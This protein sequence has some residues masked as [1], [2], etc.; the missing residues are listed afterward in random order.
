MIVSRAAVLSGL[1]LSALTG[2]CTSE[3]VTTA[4]KPVRSAV[5]GGTGSFALVPDGK[6]VK[7]YLPGYAASTNTPSLAVVDVSAPGDGVKGAPALLRQI[8]LG[9]GDGGAVEYATT[10]AG[11]STMIVAASTEASLV[12]FV[13]PASDTVIGTLRLD[14]SYGQSTFGGNGGYVTFVAM[15][16]ARN[17]AI[18]G[19]WNGLALVDLT[20]L[21][22]TKT[23]DAP[24][25]ENFAFDP[26]RQLVFAPF[27]DCAS[28]L[29]SRGNTPRACDGLTAPDGT[30]M[31]DGLSVVDLADDTVYT[32]QNPAADDPAAPVGTSPG[33]AAVDPGSGLV[34]VPSKIHQY[35][36]TIDFSRAVFDR[37][38]HVVTA[39]ATVLRGNGLTDVAIAPPDHLAFWEGENAAD[40]AA[41]RVLTL[42]PAA[43]FD[44]GVPIADAGAPMAD[45]GVPAGPDYVFS[46]MPAL[47]DGTPFTNLV[48]SHG[49]AVWPGAN[50]SAPFGIT[51]SRDG[52]WVA[53][54][55]LRTVLALPA[56]YHE[57]SDVTA[58]VT[59]LDSQ[60]PSP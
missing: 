23:I 13:D 21:A 14:A 15:D 52:R 33:S 47:P 60:T 24:P 22:I 6:S 54:V 2:A 45:A 38:T 4:A 40:I 29:D 3:N 9:D 5:A 20:T 25:S 11:D 59:F 18:L 57:L 36:T 28:S 7:L 35:Q 43:P 58:A 42:A 44:G 50:D 49:V 55:D 51:V 26:D 46:L 10:T 53:R 37:S 8:T 48:S 16:P 17:R 19:V 34:I 31:T 41:A 30:P 12:W 56:S 27:Y 32:F 1:A 39:P